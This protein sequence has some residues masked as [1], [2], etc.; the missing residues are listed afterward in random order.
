MA[1]F[2]AGDL[3]K[4][5]FP[6]TDRSTRQ[7]RPALVISANPLARD[8]GLLWVLMVTSA[9]NR[10]WPS[11]VRVSD[12]LACGLPVASVVRTAKIATIDMRDAEALGKVMP[13]VLAAVFDHVRDRLNGG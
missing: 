1:S 5:P 2:E 7:R 10:A 12:H 4:V 3:I 6:H 13:E 9:E 8:H 11:D